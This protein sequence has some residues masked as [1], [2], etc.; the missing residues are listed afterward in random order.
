MIDL[1]TFG[2]KATA[3][4]GSVMIVCNPKTGAELRTADDQPITITLASA[5]SERVRRVTRAAQNRRL[6]QARGGRNTVTVEALEAESLNSIVAA[7]IAWSNIALGDGLLPL[8]DENARRVFTELPWLREQADQ[9][10]AD[11]GNYSKTSPE[12]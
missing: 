9:H 2:T 8:N 3:E 7:T 11:R 5:D 4:E 6:A 12:T 1:T 10:M